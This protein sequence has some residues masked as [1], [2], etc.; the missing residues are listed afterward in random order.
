MN[1]P[2]KSVSVEIGPGFARLILDCPPLN[3]IDLP[4]AR[5][6]TAAANQLR[7]DA[8][9]NCVVFEARGSDFSAGVDV[10][11]H[12]PDL[13]AEMLAAFHEACFA[14]DA[15]EVPLI[16]AVQGRALGGG[17]ELTLMG[18]LVIADSDANF[19][20][21][22][23]VLGVFPPLAAVA[24]PRMIP[25]RLASEM[26]L[27]GQTLGAEEAMRV[28]LINSMV[29]PD[30]LP[31]AVESAARAFASLSRSS[32]TATKAALRFARVRPTFEEVK[33]S[34]KLYLDRLLNDPDAI[35]GL[36]AFIEKRPARWRSSP[37]S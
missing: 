8:S 19:G 25:L 2:R 5:E 12:L 11:S 33:A 16:V 22:E 28:G 10:R 32:L 18:D 30:E 21:P 24:L 4:T 36:N 23:I 17:C 13:G 14:L 26:I 15:L 35:E 34:E 9:L 31:S 7:A 3:V 6:L 37:S 1:A 29:P 20:L 27:R